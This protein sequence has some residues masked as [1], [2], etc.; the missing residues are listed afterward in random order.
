MLSPVVDVDWVVSASNTANAIISQ[1]ARV[2]STGC[3]K[4]RALVGG[5]QWDTDPGFWGQGFFVDYD[6]SHGR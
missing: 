6:G 2:G 1:A 5:E 3:V 4:D